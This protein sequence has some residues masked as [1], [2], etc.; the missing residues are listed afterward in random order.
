MNPENVKTLIKNRPLFWEKIEIKCNLECYIFQLL[1]CIVVIAKVWLSL[2][3]SYV[4]FYNTFLLLLQ[5]ENETL[6]VTSGPTRLT[7]KLCGTGFRPTCE[8]TPDNVYN[9]IRNT[10][11]HLNSKFTFRVIVRLFKF[12]FWLFFFLVF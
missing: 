3:L 2:V 7:V 6:D 10:H 8:I 11:E 1:N 12:S 5:K 4:F 9:V